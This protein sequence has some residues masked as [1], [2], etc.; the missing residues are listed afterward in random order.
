MR[1]KINKSRCFLMFITFFYITFFPAIHH[2]SFVRL[3]CQGIHTKL[4]N[5]YKGQYCW[6]CFHHKHYTL[7][8]IKFWENTTCCYSIYNMYKEMVITLMSLVLKLYYSSM[9][10][11]WCPGYHHRQVTINHNLN[12]QYKWFFASTR[13]NFNFLY[14]L[15][16]EIGMMIQIVPKVNAVNLTHPSHKL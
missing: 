3:S 9:S 7:P 13:Y 10:I 16:V 2:Q 15:M 5:K 1:N 11:P 12:T 6:W 4:F 8:A 14:H